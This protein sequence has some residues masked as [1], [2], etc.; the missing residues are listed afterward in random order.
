MAGFLLDPFW[1]YVVEGVLVVFAL[2][3]A[4]VWP[5]GRLAPLMRVETALAKLAERPVRQA[6]L[7]IA[8][9]VGLRAILLP[10]YG[11][12][13]PYISDEFS[14]LL[15]AQTFLEG[16]FA[17]PTHPLYPFFETPYV[18]QIPTYASMYFPGRGAPLALG[19]LLTGN[20][21]LGVWL[22]MVLLALAMV[23]MLR[24]WVSD[25]LALVG[26]VLVVLR[27]GV[28][29]G[30]IN[31]YYGGGLI[32][33]GGVLVLGAFPRLMRQPRWRDGI[34]MG[35]GLLL[36][37]TS[38][39]FE[40]FMF[41]L[42][43]LLVGGWRLIGLLRQRAFG[44][45]RRLALPAFV[46]TGCG[47]ALMLVNNW[48]I[49][50]DPLHDPY[51]LNRETYAHAPAFLTGERL[52]PR[53]PVPVSVGRYYR[54]ESEPFGKQYSISGLIKIE[55]EK[56]KRL[57]NFYIGPVFLIP[58][59]LGLLRA[60]RAPILL[61]SGGTLMLGFLVTTWHWSQYLAP[62]FGLFWI[63]IMS[64]FDVLRKWRPRGRPSGLVFS[65]LLAT[66]AAVSL[67][68][69]MAGVFAGIPEREIEAFVRP[70]CAVLTQT[71]RSRI[72]EQLRATPGRDLVIH[73]VAPDIKGVK[74][75]L[76]VN[77]PDID[78]ADIVWA[79]DLGPRN[80]ELLDYY[81]DRRVWLVN[82]YDE[83]RATA[84]DRTA[85]ERE[86]VRSQR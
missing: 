8:L 19:L 67:A 56:L 13:V 15:Q 62:G 44:L 48:A 17:N 5:A 6:L 52:L 72:I 45:A 73:R 33:L 30:W 75:F 31:T 21:W 50:G 79:H 3:A 58:F 83:D 7:V 29:S 20:A 65:R 11:T 24:A 51:T 64:G 39:P 63:F 26:G 40:G 22:S 57:A 36:L 12:P 61:V 55:V 85:L 77:E 53:H 28:L 25:G 10:V 86:L 18:S 54:G 82:G 14:L 9:A 78:A 32:A 47:A 35:C 76:V 70:C 27:Y 84:V 81:P 59:V 71:P 68:M 60:R 2:A 80:R 23:W 41:S 34:A 66:I 43:F 1:I 16:R 4:L 69:P 49:T 37:M 38:R 46:L 74:S 42:P